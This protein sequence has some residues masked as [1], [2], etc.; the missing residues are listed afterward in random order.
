MSSTASSHH[1]RKLLRTSSLT[2]SIDRLFATVAAVSTALVLAQ[3][4]DWRLSRWLLAAV[5]LLWIV[6]V[7]LT[8]LLPTALVMRELVRAPGGESAGIGAWALAALAAIGVTLSL[9]HETLLGLLRLADRHADLVFNIDH[10]YLLMHAWSMIRNEGAGE[11][12]S[13]VGTPIA[14]HSGPAWFA[15]AMGSTLGTGPDAWLFLWFPVA[16]VLTIAVAMFTLIRGLTTGTIPA[17]VGMAVAF[18]PVWDHISVAE[19]RAVASTFVNVGP[20]AALSATSGLLF[21]VNQTMMLNSLLGFAIVVTA[22]AFFVARQTPSAFVGANVVVILS[23]V[24]KPQYAISGSI[25]LFGLGIALRRGLVPRP[26]VGL[27]VVSTFAAV[28]L[29]DLAVGGSSLAGVRSTGW[30][31]AIP[32]DWSAVDPFL[33]S[34]FRFVLVVL[35]LAFGAVVILRGGARDFERQAVV[36]GGMGILGLSAYWTLLHFVVAA[37]GDPVRIWAWNAMQAASPVLTVSLAI[38]AAMVYAVVRRVSRPAVVILALAIVASVT[39]SGH[40]IVRVVRDPHAGHEAVDAPYVRDL[41][42]DV[43]PSNAIILASDLSDPAQGHRRSGRAFYLSNAFG[44]QFWLTQTGYGHEQLAETTRRV[45]ALNRFFDTEWS[46][47]HAD[48]LEG[49]GVTHVAVNDRC[50]ATWK[51]D[52]VPMLTEV[53]ATAS[54]RLFEVAPP[55]SLWRESFEQVPQAAVVAGADVATQPLFGRAAC[56]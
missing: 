2:S 21:E 49:E 44:H 52:D 6:V 53:A 24:A 23:S 40:E 55:S 38:V 37:G 20:V 50:P 48:L 13:M 47:W 42:S 46:E 19:T 7:L 17:L 8:C 45:Q 1:G 51:P 27:P 4:L 25:L 18:A 54:W 33:P 35:G 36:V 26:L 29:S 34:E 39:A 11:A 16:A 14:Y 12:L 15:A 3:W 41:L 56:R 22:L 28:G 9:F 5:F 31:I 32:D 30:T 10:R 43:N